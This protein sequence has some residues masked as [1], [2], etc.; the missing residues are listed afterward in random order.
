MLFSLFAIACSESEPTNQE[1]DFDILKEFSAQL[2]G[3]FTSEA[4]SI[5]NPSYYA[6]QLHAC[7]V[8][9]PTLGSHVLYIEQALADNTGSPYRQRF[10]VLSD[11]GEDKVRSEIYTLENPESFIGLCTE[12][13]IASF[14]AS[15]ATQ[16][17][18]CHVELEWN[19]TGFEGK[20]QEG[21]CPSDI[22]GASYATSI[23]QTTP[24]QISSW[25]QGWDA[26]G[27]QVWGAIEGAYLFDRKE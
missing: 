5:S 9:V 3:R 14:E 10:Y 13:K 21:T 27:N 17:I 15:V 8:D 23:V 16:K 19:G 18:G 2:S 24:T 25:D 7:P 4:Q 11:L 1:L 20:T 22:N 6:I 26:N 12:D